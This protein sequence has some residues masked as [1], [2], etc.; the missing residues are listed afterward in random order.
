L[1]APTR[2]AVPIE[3]DADLDAVAVVHD[4]GQNHAAEAEHRADREIDAPRDDHDRH[5]ER[6]DRDKGKIARDVE[7]IV[8]G[9]EGIGR[10]CEKNA[11]GDERQ[12]YPE[13][14]ARRQPGEPCV[15]ILL[16]RNVELDCH[17]SNPE[18]RAR[19]APSRRR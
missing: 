9:G 7:Q 13:G 15:L 17:V 10:K 11:R 2:S 19:L 14:L 12:E 5:A 8:G 1:T 6:D 3:A 18:C 16:D 4:H